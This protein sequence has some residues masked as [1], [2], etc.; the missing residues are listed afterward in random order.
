MSHH[1]LETNTINSDNVKVRYDVIGVEA[2]SPLLRLLL[3]L[4][5]AMT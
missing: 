3:L 4:L 2:M 1:Y 5:V